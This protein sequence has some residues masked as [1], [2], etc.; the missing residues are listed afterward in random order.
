MHRHHDNVGKALSQPS[1]ASAG[2]PGRTTW[3][4]CCGDIF[5]TYVVPENTK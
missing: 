3:L 1:E 5:I 4:L 2:N